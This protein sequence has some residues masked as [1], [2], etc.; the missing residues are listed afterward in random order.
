MSV[1]AVGGLSENVGVAQT[2]TNGTVVTINAD[3]S[4]TVDPTGCNTSGGD[5]VDTLEYSVSNGDAEAS[6]T[7]TVTIL[8]NVAGYQRP[9]SAA[10][11]VIFDSTE[12]TRS[13]P[14][15]ADAAWE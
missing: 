11:D 12:Y 10:A 13:A 15:S 1:V 2:L 9:D 4:Y 8:S 6:A 3:G 5:V 7:L 14:T